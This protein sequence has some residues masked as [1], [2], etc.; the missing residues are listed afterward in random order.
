MRRIQW[1]LFSLMVV[2]V[3]CGQEVPVEAP[4]HEPFSLSEPAPEYLDLKTPDPKNL[5]ED[6][7]IPEL[8]QDQENLRSRHFKK[9]FQK[10]EALEEWPH[11]EIPVELLRISADVK[12]SKLGWNLYLLWDPSEKKPSGLAL[13]DSKAAEEQAKNEI[14]PNILDLQRQ[15]QE[16]LQKGIYGAGVPKGPLLQTFSNSSSRVFS[17]EDLS[18][19]EYGTSVYTYEEDDV[20]WVHLDE[21]RYDREGLKATLKLTYASSLFPSTKLEQHVLSIRQKSTS[22]YGPGKWEVE[23]SLEDKSEK[24]SVSQLRLSTHMTG[25][26]PAETQIQKNWKSLKAIEVKS[27]N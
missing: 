27:K 15:E 19:E 6:F 1:L 5:S 12:D 26:N 11:T 18:Q 10:A 14:F 16:N 24:V 23:G 17:S 3:A 2:A 25:L 4:S 22:E 13:K 8:S 7:V 21:F 20:I 9:I